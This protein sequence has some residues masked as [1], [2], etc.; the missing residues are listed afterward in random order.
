[1]VRG[2]HAEDVT[3]P[4]VHRSGVELVALK[5]CSLRALPLNAG[6]ARGQLLWG[7]HGDLVWKRWMQVQR[8]DGRRLAPPGAGSR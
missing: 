2:P 3:Q 8:L 6:I 4:S 7:V 5:A 1:M